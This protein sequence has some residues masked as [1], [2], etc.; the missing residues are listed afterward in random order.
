[1]PAALLL[2]QK[3]LFLFFPLHG[4][5]TQEKRRKVASFACTVVALIQHLHCR[6]YHTASALS[7]PS[8]NT[9]MAGCSVTTTK[10]PPKPH[11][12]STKS[13]SSKY[14]DPKHLPVCH[15]HHPLPTPTQ[16]LKI[17]SACSLISLSKLV[18][19]RLETA[20]D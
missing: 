8:H 4:L 11:Q 19:W 9:S 10:M 5:D 1:M 7:R 17:F 3:F 15:L 20:R 2:Y 14:H 18:A 12:Q 6:G 16:I 13:P